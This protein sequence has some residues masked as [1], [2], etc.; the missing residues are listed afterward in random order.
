MRCT[1]AGSEK[2]QKNT[3]TGEEV[4]ATWLSEIHP[5]YLCSDITY[6]GCVQTPRGIVKSA[7]MSKYWA[8]RWC[9]LTKLD[10][11]VAEYVDGKVRS[12]IE[13]AKEN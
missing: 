13:Q 12:W 1:P 7:A 11:P 10:I 4:M 9:H 8:E 5:M 2:K 3:K 6:R